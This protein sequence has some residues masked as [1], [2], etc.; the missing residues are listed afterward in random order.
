MTVM[1]Q[2]TE[3][4]PL[5]GRGIL[6][7]IQK[8]MIKADTDLLIYERG[9]R[10]VNDAFKYCVRIIY[11]QYILLLHKLFEGFRKFSCHSKT[12][13]LIIKDTRCHIYWIFLVPQPTERFQCDFKVWTQFR[14]K[15]RCLRCSE[16]F[17]TT[18]SS[19]HERRCRI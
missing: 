19:F 7:L 13:D 8:K 12:I 3:I 10:S 9:I 5:Y 16:P 6:K 4:V 18:R 17:F 1:K 2:R 15:L 14:E 11:T